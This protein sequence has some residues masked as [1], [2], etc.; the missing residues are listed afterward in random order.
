VVL[1]LGDK[2]S[3]HQ[4]RT[5]AAFVP[6][7]WGAG[8]VTAANL[9]EVRRE[10]RYLLGFNEP[11][12]SGQSN[13]TVAQALA[14]WPKLMA[15]GTRLGSPAV[16]TG[17]ATPGGWLDQFMRG[18]KARH[19]RVNFIAVHWYGNDFSTRAAVLRLKSY[20]RAI[21]ARYRLPI[22]LTEFALIRF[23]GTVTFPSTAQQAAFVT[24]ATAMLRQLPHVQRTPGSHCRPLP[25][26]ARPG[27]S[28]RVR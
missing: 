9:R 13:M 16:A 4:E 15:T 23:G 12:N 8:T 1:Q 14:L 25:A 20:L 2:S 18:A 19:Y 26:T 28:G 22:W 10:G 3:E 7:I 21:Y 24:A 11:D 5:G 17:A 6:M 27:F